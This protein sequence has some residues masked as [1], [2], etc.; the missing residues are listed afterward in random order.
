MSFL[1]IS[2]GVPLF[3]RVSVSG[4]KNAA[5]PIIFASL[6]VD[7]VS[8]IENVPDIGDVRVAIEVISDLGA[9]VKRRSGTLT[10]DTGAL[11]YK[12]PLHHN[13]F[14]YS[15]NLT[16]SLFYASLRARAL[17]SY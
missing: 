3:G 8:V 6:T 13:C 7:G 11:A 4:S 16:R 5:L 17:L 9:T 2:G 1:E 14:C 15:N 10:V 12:K